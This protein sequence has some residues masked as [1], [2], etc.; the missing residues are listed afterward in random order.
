MDNNIIKNSSSEY[1]DNSNLDRNTENNVNIN[2][3]KLKKNNNNHFNLN[4]N[5]QKEK[6]IT[7][8]ITSRKKDDEEQRYINKSLLTIDTDD[9]VRQYL[10]TNEGDLNENEKDF[11]KKYFKVQRE[12][13]QDKTKLISLYNN[14]NNIFNQGLQKY[15]DKEEN[16]EVI[17][18]LRQKRKKK[19]NRNDPNRYSKLVDLY[20]VISRIYFNPKLTFKRIR[21]NFPNSDDYTDFLIYLYK[22]G[23]INI[24]RNG[25]GVSMELDD[26][27][28]S[29]MDII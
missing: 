23:I 5:K 21:N 15:K 3:D 22:L 17:K 12:I 4:L 11:A 27:V 9:I 28:T 24:H 19:K 10:G 6:K 20:S 7:D 8:I 1:N 16:N 25:D 29:F 14:E 18:F 2:K 26:N 13:L